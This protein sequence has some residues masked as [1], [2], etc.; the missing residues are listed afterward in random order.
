MEDKDMFVE[1]D[2]EKITFEELSDICGLS[3][4]DFRRLMECITCQH[5]PKTCGCTESDEDEK[6]HCQK[7]KGRE[8]LK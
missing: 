2:G 4:N 8:D 1:V 7:Y 6:G 3:T 5:D